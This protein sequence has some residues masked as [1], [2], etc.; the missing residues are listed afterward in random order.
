MEMEKIVL[1]ANNNFKDGNVVVQVKNLSGLIKYLK[2]NGVDPTEMSLESYDELCKIC[3]SINNM[4]SSIL[5]L[6][7]YKVY[8]ENDFFFS[9]ALAYCN[10][11]GIELKEDMIDVGKQDASD[12]REF[13]DKNEDLDSVRLYLKEIGQYKLLSREEMRDLFIRY[14]KANTEEEKRNIQNIIINHNLRLVVG[15]AKKMTGR[16]VPFLDLIQEGSLGLMKAVEKY[17]YTKGYQFS[18][19]ASWW[20]KQA[21]NRCLANDS[22]TIRIPVHAHE[23]LNKVNH[24][25][26][27]Y[28]QEN[29][30]YPKTEVI[31]EALNIPEDKLVY[32]LT[33]QNIISLDAPIKNDEG[34]EDSSLNDFLVDPTFFEGDAMREALK[35]D[36]YRALDSTNLTERERFVLNERFGLDG[37]VPKTLEEVGAE[38]KVTRER[39]RQIEVKALRK[40]RHSKALREFNASDFANDS[41]N[42]S[43]VLKQK[44]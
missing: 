34:S 24:F 12:L 7:D 9:L 32:L 42:S 30:H 14:T 20:I 8:L 22:R 25:A 43:L 40:L 13:I 16:G 38:Y 33:T 21:V 31:S 19:Y 29:G 39:I 5:Q 10:N 17:D 36:F 37:G 23:L 11:N 28:L 27:V 15:F 4:V 6:D 44:N 1:Y 2:S 26:A 41:Y 18:T 3:P 35:V